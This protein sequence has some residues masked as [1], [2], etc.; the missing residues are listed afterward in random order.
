MVGVLPYPALSLPALPWPVLTSAGP[1]L[2][3]R[4]P[5]LLT[6]PARHVCTCMITD[7]GNSPNKAWQHLQ[8]RSA[9]FIMEPAI[10]CTALMA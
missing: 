3:Y 1:N 8:C 10:P 5:T 6:Y 7:A 9:V 2:A 4:D